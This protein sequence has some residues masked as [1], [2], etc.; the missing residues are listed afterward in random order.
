MI[1]INDMPLEFLNEKLNNV[2]VDGYCYYKSKSI[3]QNQGY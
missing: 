1:K 2:G 3:N